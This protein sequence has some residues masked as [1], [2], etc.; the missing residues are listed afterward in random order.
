[1]AGKKRSLAVNAVLNCLRVCSNIIIPL[2]S[3]PWLTRVLHAEN[4]GKV[5]F[6][7]SLVAWF[8]LAAGLGIGAYSIRE[9][10]RLRENREKLSRFCDEIF[11]INLFSAALAYGLLAAFLLIWRPGGDYPYIIAVLSVGILGGTLSFDWLPNVMEDFRFI[12]VRV[13]SIQFLALCAIFA[14]VRRPEDYVIYAWITAAS[15]IASAALNFAYA[16]RNI[17]IVPAWNF[18]WKSRLRPILILFGNALM[19]SIYLQSDITMLGFFRGE[20]EV[21]LYKIPVQI[22]SAVKTMLN[23]I[24][25]VA[26]PRM[27]LYLSADRKEDYHKLASMILSCLAYLCIPAMLGLCLIA[28]NCVL[29][30]GGNEYV[31]STPAL[32]ILCLALVAAVFGNF[33]VNA[34]LIVHR[35]EKSAFTATVVSA[36]VNIVLNLALIPAVGFVGAALTTLAAEIVVVTLLAY[37]SRAYVRVWPDRKVIAPMCMGSALILLSCRFVDGLQLNL[38]PD[39]ALKIALSVLAYGMVTGVAAAF[40]VAGKRRRKQERM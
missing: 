31:S 33:Y 5:S 24:T 6:C 17:R 35:R 20:R 29:L 28:E 23:A 18:D 25:V 7:S 1:M 32:R 36:L 11:T 22:Y 21:G 9:G 15:S 30:I 4:F 37:F 39:T 16:R 14:F 26:V 3:F 8:V 10:A 38:A 19:I 13:V 40:A 2:I 27:S 12:T 34:V